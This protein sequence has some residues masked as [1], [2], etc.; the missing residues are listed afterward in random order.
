[1]FYDLPTVLSIRVIYYNE[2]SYVCSHCPWRSVSMKYQKVSAK[3]PEIVYEAFT[4]ENR[5]RSYLKIV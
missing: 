3:N 1:M 2:Y 5:P 4:R